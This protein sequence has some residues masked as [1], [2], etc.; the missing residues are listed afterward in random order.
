[1]KIPFLGPVAVIA[2][3]L[4]MKPAPATS[5]ITADARSTLSVIFE[6][7]LFYHT[8]RDYTNGVEISWSTS[9]K[10][11]QL[12]PAS[13]QASLSNVFRLRD[14]RASFSLGQMMFTPEHTA[15]VTP[16]IG[17]RPYAGFL[18]GAMA[19]TD[20]DGTEQNQLRVQLGVIGPASLAADSQKVIHGLR[21]FDF[22]KGWN[23]QLR[24]EP[25]MVVTYQKSRTIESATAENGAGFDI[26]AHVGGAVG[27]VFDY[28]NTGFVGRVG[29]HMPSDDG[30]PRMT[31]AVAG[32]YNYEPDGAFGA[33]LFAG[34]EARLVGRNLFLDGNSFQS[35]RS[36]DKK[37]L[38]GD[39][40]VGGAIAFEDFQLSF[41]HVFR[42]PEYARQKD[43][44]QFG[45]L[46]LSVN[47]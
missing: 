39:F 8:D 16:P 14:A 20:D 31:P 18:Y 13:I 11:T 15:L 12:L 27:N 25:G 28:L 10:G 33:Y 3:L 46:N 32:S 9:G 23:T 4:M 30:P 17:E 5:A 43:F 37:P 2:A 19:L 45:T 34:A 36:V 24:D 35:S 29:F 22:P 47:L 40:M 7:D 6:N 42:S 44:D 26:R 1:M 38:V 21:G 41:V